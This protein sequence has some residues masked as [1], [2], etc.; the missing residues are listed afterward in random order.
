MS[1]HCVLSSI[2]WN[3]MRNDLKGSNLNWLIDLFLQELPNYLNELNTAVNHGDGDK[4]YLAAHKFK[5]ACSNLGANGMV[6]LC[7][8]LETLG[9]A[10]EIQQAGNLLKNDVESESK[11]LHEAL[12][13]EKR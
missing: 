2:I 11:L 12:I 13:Q 10:G 9:Q 5:G 7:K 8:R 3:R 6:E 1:E 4:L